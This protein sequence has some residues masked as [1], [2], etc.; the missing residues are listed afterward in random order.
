MTVT[1]DR[2]TSDYNFRVRK[3]SAEHMLALREHNV[4]FG[5]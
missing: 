3:Q 4:R 2:E 5:P 1:L